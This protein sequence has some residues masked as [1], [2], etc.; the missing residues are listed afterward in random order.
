[1]KYL[2]LF[3]PYGSIILALWMLSGIGLAA[4]KKSVLVI[5][6]YHA[7]YQWDADYTRAIR[8]VLGTTAE[9]SFFQLNTKRLP[10][11]M[12]ARK[13]EQAWNQYVEIEPDL[14][15][16]GDDNALKYLG[17][18]FAKTDTPVIYL[19]INNNPR[20]YFSNRP[21]NITGVLERPLL[22]RSVIYVAEIMGR[23]LDK[24]LILFDNG[25]T[26]KTIFEE[27]F[28]GDSHRTIGPVDVHIKLIDE[29]DDWHDAILTAPEQGYD[30][31]IMGLYHTIVTADGEHVPEQEVISWTSAQTR[32]PLFGY[33][34]FSVGADMTIGGYVLDAYAQGKQAA[35][36][37]LKA[38]KGE[39]LVLMPQSSDEGQFVFSRSQ[40]NK[41]N[42]DLPKKVV[43]Q[44][45]FLP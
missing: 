27:E 6:S 12:H 36:M 7:S 32:I 17:P 10:L 1:M 34:Q 2:P 11:P 37:A 19:G 33:W 16:L 35:L 5:E 25:T 4:E 31:V 20:N 39:R 44:S 29:I 41:W 45:T 15:I 26:S 28:Q 24:V 9:L 23:S 3:T 8:D 18:R 30:A 42:I 43:E 22:K 14:V 40:L 13:V 21:N 38:L